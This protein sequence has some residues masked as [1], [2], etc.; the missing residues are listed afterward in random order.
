MVKCKLT[1]FP[2]FFKSFHPTFSLCVW[3]SLYK[4]SYFSL[5]KFRHAR[6]EGEKEKEQKEEEGF[7]KLEKERGGSNEEEEISCIYWHCGTKIKGQAR[8][9]HGILSFSPEGW[10]HF[11][12]VLSHPSEPNPALQKAYK[13][14]KK[15]ISSILN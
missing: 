7:E 15:L 5:Q 14:Y 9:E 2:V 8:I 11:F 4:P 3:H 12:E 6:C 1:R 13:C 10:A